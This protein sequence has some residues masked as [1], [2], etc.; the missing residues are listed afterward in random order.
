MAHRYPHPPVAGRRPE[1]SQHFARDTVARLIAARLPQRPRLVVE[2]GA[3]AG[4]ITQALADRRLRVIAI[5]KDPVL[6]R[7]LRSRFA[8]NPAVECILGDF[9]ELP[10]P[11]EPYAF[12]S[13]VPF[14]ITAAVV[15][16]LLAATPP[17]REALLV[18]QREAAERFTGRPRSTRVALLHAPWFEIA[19]ERR[20]HRDDFVPA[21]SVD[22]V[23]MRIRPRLCSL[24]PATLDRD[25][26]DFINGAFGTRRQQARDAL[27]AYFTER[28][29]VRLAREFGFDRHARPSEISVEAWLGLFRFHAQGRLGRGARTR[30]RDV[31]PWRPRRRLTPSLHNAKLVARRNAGIQP[32]HYERYL[33]G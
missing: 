10:L 13:N 22:C 31:A 11:G 24:V 18:V 32:T 25:Y 27:R 4:A 6:Y 29:L 21:P 7:I 9:L 14:G 15:G 12:V 33:E 2:A 16:R 28:Q 19:V 5:E 1:L 30:C 17:P 8:S 20:F 3:G 26:R 23:L